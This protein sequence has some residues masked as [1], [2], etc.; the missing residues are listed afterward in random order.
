M[1]EEYKYS[2]DMSYDPKGARIW[3]T[4]T[5]KSR[6]TQ[7][8]GLSLIPVEAKLDFLWSVAVEVVRLALRFSGSKPQIGL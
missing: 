6:L 8:L 2:P 7:A 1:L 5:R 4:N 3:G